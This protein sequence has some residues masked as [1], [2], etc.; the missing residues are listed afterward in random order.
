M[1][2]GPAVVCG[3]VGLAVPPQAGWVL[4]GAVCRPEFPKSWQDA[5]MT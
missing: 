4:P 5:R 2:V 1:Q 3:A